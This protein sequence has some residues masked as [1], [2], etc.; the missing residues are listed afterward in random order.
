MI[1][2][3]AVNPKSSWLTWFFRGIL[4][5]AIFI[6]LGRLA[7][8]QIIKGE[9]Y[10][11]LSDG[12]RARRVAI[13]AARGKI[14]A[15]DGEVLVDSIP[16]GKTVK[17]DP[18]QGY[19]KVTPDEN[20]KTEDIITEWDRAYPLASASGHLTGY[21][22]EVNEEE[23]GKV[24]QECIEKGTKTLGTYNGRSGLEYQYDCLLRG[25]DGEEIVEVDTL[26]NKIR[27]LG[28]KAPVA[29]SDL[30]TTIDFKLQKKV[31]EAMGSQIGAVIVSSPDGAIHA[32]YSNP[33][34]DPNSDIAKLFSD[35]SLPLFNRAI[36]G[37]YHPGSIFKMVTSTAAMEE[38]AIQPDY[39]YDDTGIIKIDE[40]E[41]RNWYFTQYG[42]QEGLVDTVKALARS[43]DTFYYKVG[44][45]VGIDNLVNWS[46]KYGLKDRTGIDL[47]GEVAGLVPSPEWKK[48][49]KGER[50]FLGNTYHFSIGQGDLSVTPIA[51]SRIAQVISNGGRLCRPYINSELTASCKDLEIE[52]MHLNTIKAGMKA[53]C[54]PGGTGVPFFEFPVEVGCKTGTAE[55]FEENITH[56]WFTVF[57]PYENPEYI[58]TVLVEKGGEGSKVAAP[59]AR[60]ILDFVYNP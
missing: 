7:E 29:G 40:Y 1:E 48:A 25:I 6:I 45:L 27:T 33:S 8:L 15:K 16:V 50:W 3:F 42:G 14:V 41:Y 12:N 23:L 10:Q 26:G 55:T 59:I 18:L 49:V 17:F 11:N 28:R 31:Q 13:K 37:V 35:K 46:E 20:T 4:V 43:T 52:P 60:E 19:E 22:G 38:G 54:D 58:V 56:A 9:Y 53:A 57:A 47:P 39:Q 44:E 34:Y 36:G 32:L 5:I 24:D 2:N 21:L 51:A 30:K